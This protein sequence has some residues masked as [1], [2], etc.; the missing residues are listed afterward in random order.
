MEIY[1]LNISKNA[2]NMVFKKISSTAGS[3]MTWVKD[4]VHLEVRSP[5]NLKNT[6]LTWPFVFPYM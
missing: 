6:L 4:R 5:P 2:K 3:I 1:F